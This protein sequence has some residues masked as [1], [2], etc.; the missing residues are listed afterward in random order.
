MLVMVKIQE[1][2]TFHR[3]NPNDQSLENSCTAI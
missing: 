1:I 3:I 2:L